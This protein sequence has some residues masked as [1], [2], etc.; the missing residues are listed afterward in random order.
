MRSEI[1]QRPIGP[2]DGEALKQITT[3]AHTRMTMAWR[4]TRPVA[5][6]AG[7]SG[8]WYWVE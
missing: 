3:S 2:Q 5:P 6:A 4:G 7:R 1:D 8:T